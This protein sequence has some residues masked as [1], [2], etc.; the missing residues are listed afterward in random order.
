ML[1]VIYG[2]TLNVGDKTRNYLKSKGFK[3]IKKAISE[4][5]I[6]SS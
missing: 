3:V 1:L 6:K 2:L 5:D 4:E